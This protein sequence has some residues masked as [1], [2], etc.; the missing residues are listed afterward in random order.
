MAVM[1]ATIMDSNFNI[2]GIVDD[3]QS[4]IWTERYGEAGDFEIYGDTKSSISELAKLGNYVRIPESDRTMIIENIQVDE[5]N[6]S[7]KILV[8]G[9]SLESILTRRIVWTQTIFNK[10]AGATGVKVQDILKKLFNDNLI[11]PSNTKR[12][13]NNFTF[14]E[15]TD[16]AITNLEVES[17]QFIGDTLYDIVKN[18]CEVYNI[19]FKLVQD[20]NNNMIFGLYSGIDRS[21][22]QST[23][24]FVVYS[25]EFDNIVSSNFKDNISEFKNIILVG[26]E[27]NANNVR[28]VETYTTEETE[29]EG[30]SR[31]EMF[32]DAKDV[33]IKDDNGHVIPDATYK[34]QLK[35]RGS[36]KIADKDH[37]WKFDAQIDTVKS[38]QFK[39]DYYLG[40]ILQLVGILDIS[41]KLR[42]TT[43]I[44]CNDSR[45]YSAYPQ[46]KI[47]DLNENS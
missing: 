38:Y 4:I 9:R 34:E 24:S 42:I 41:A 45:G 25:K 23:N 3:Y 1:E 5:S 36:E 21:Y 29:P 40:D 44:R 6:N 46:F 2:I 33:S 22:D 47:I 30:L 14:Y 15:S 20:D 37:D 19:G 8:S 10:A 27:Y 32:D 13:I 11:N 35:T 26:G 18:F 12:K 31:Y 28:L 17:A 43:F 7:N 39:K 16:T